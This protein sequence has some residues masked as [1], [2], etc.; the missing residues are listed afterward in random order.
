MLEAGALVAKPGHQWRPAERSS[1]RKQRVERRDLSVQ[2]ALGLGNVTRWCA[3]RRRGPGEAGR[4]GFGRA[5]RQRER[6]VIEHGIRLA[7]GGQS[8]SG[9]SFGG[10]KTAGRPFGV[11]WRCSKLAAR[12]QPRRHS[13]LEMPAT[14]IRRR[15]QRRFGVEQAR[16]R[17]PDTRS[18][19]TV[20]KAQA[21]RSRAG[22]SNGFS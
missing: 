21:C 19:A 3:A 11:R 18:E 22:R 17:K 13:R 8:L 14:A 15:R 6:G 2:G 7:D 9:L 20:V 5:R 10:R 12:H 4:R 16:K 1:E